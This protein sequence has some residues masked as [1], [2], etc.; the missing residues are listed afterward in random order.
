MRKF[1]ACASILVILTS[2]SPPQDPCASA[3]A[4]ITFGSLLTNRLSGAYDACLDERRAE[5]ARLRMEA[6]RLDAEANRL[7]EA[8]N[9]QDA[10]RA[11]LTRRLAEVNVRQ[12]EI[13]RAL[14]SAESR[15]GIERSRLDMLLARE[16]A[17]RERIAKASS[18]DD[19]AEL[20]GIEASQASILVSIQ[21]MI[22][23]IAAE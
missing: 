13:I 2:C 18:D 17:L 15:S 9:N 23:A 19:E 1:V 7:R 12:A 21:G 3:N 20:R 6:S 8:A 22:N 10:E 14:S 11:R 5:L 4:D 16:A